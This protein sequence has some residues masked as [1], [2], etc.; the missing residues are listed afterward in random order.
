MMQLAPQLCHTIELE[1][2]Q[3]T[4]QALM[5]AATELSEHYRSQRSASSRVMADSCTTRV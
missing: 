5:Q 3:H 4:L 2:A 1:T